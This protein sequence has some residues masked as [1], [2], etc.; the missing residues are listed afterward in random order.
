MSMFDDKVLGVLLL[1]LSTTRSGLEMHLQSF[2][3]WHCSR[4]SLTSKGTK[5]GTNLA[6]QMVV[7]V[8]LKLLCKS[9]LESKCFWKDPI[10]IRGTQL[11]F[12]GVSIY[13]A[14]TEFSCCLRRGR[15]NRFS[16]TIPYHCN[17][18]GKRN[19]EHGWNVTHCSISVCKVCLWTVHH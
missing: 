18:A 3:E 12:A 16:L 6:M 8:G 15:D 7:S 10:G 4:W 11:L 2:H 14:C 5:W 19:F 13:G 1:L 9:F 17:E